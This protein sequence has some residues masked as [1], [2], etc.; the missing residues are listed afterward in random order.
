LVA[1]AMRSLRHCDRAPLIRL[2]LYK[3]VF[4]WAIV[5]VARLLEHWIR[6]WLVEHHPI[7]TFL[8][9]MAYIRL[10]SLHSDPALDIRSVPDL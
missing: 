1:N 5:F 2:I 8:P 7:G 4:Y 6:F 9:H 10:A 3:S